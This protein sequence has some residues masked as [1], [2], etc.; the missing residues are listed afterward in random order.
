MAKKIALA[1]LAG[2]FGQVGRDTKARLRV[3]VGN[4]FRGRRMAPGEAKRAP[5]PTS[6]T[7][8]IDKV[9]LLMSKNRA[10]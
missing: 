9:G 8:S 10:R 6:K 5:K 2:G 3:A 1:E 4:G 7:G